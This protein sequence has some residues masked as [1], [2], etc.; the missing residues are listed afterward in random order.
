MKRTLF[1][2]AL[3]LA[4]FGGCASVEPLLSADARIERNFGY[5]AALSYTTTAKGFSVV[6]KNTATGSQYGVP[7]G[8]NVSTLPNLSDKITAIKV[9]VGTYQIVG[10]THGTGYLRTWTPG[11]LHPVSESFSV[12][13]G[14]VVALG[15]FVIDYSSVL[16]YPSI[17]ERNAIAASNVSRKE[18]HDAFRSAYASFNEKAF[19]CFLCSE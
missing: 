7:L 8:E 17:H 10:W 3:V 9:P 15:R 11:K 2:A 18:L 13:E 14:S 12:Q 1:V 6:V 4:A 16:K 19:S 5:L